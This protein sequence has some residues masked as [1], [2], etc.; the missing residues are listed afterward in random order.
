MSVA[1]T[2]AARRRIKASPSNKKVT[3]RNKARGKNKKSLSGGAK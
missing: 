2:R 3:Q 1:Q